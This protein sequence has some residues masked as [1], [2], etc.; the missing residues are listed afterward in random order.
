MLITPRHLRRF[1]G[2]LGLYG[3]RSGRWWL[4]VMVP[5]LAVAAIAVTA[6]KVAVPTVVYAFF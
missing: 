2:D 3:F 1:A 5:L 4:A 6:V